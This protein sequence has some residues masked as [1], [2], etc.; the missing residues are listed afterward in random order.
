MGKLGLAKLQKIVARLPLPPGYF[1]RVSSYEGSGRGWGKGREADTYVVTFETDMTYGPYRYQGSGRKLIMNGALEVASGTLE[2]TW[3]ILTDYRKLRRNVGRVVRHERANLRKAEKELE[4]QRRE[5]QMA[6][7]TGTQAL[8]VLSS[9][10][11]R[12]AK[13]L[14]GGIEVTVSFGGA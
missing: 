10:I 2:E 8:R 12:R 1:L 6:A 13:T 7:R 9:L 3:D 11:P 14:V 4:L 5:T